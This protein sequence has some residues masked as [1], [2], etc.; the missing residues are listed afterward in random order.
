[1]KLRDML[2]A[3]H[4]DTRALIS[5]YEN[6]IDAQNEDMNAVTTCA[7]DDPRDAEKLHAVLDA[8]VISFQ[9]VAWGSKL[10]IYCREASK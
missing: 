4:K 2:S 1:M 10:L 6:A 8:D 5:V 3:M 9:A 7:T